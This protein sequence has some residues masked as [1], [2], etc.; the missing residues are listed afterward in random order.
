Q[1]S[2]VLRENKKSQRVR[3]CQGATWLP[4]TAG[5]RVAQKLSARRK[6]RGKG[7]EEKRH[8]RGTESP[9]SQAPKPYPLS[10]V[11]KVPLLQSDCCPVGAGVWKL[12]TGSWDSVSEKYEEEEQEK[13]LKV[14]EVRRALTPSIPKTQDRLTQVMRCVKY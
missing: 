13:W 8:G 1:H 5:E 6:G 10:S 9:Q 3:G 2:S 7:E 4:Q 11:R 12:V 14:I